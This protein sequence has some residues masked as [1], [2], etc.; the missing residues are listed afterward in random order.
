MIGK[1]RR[2][3]ISNERVARDFASRMIGLSS[4]FEMTPLPDG[5]FEAVVKDEPDVVE[6][7]SRAEED[8]LPK[9][10]GEW[11]DEELLSLALEYI[12]NQQS[13]EAWE[14]FLKEAK[15]TKARG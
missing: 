7:A 8:T 4:W 3:M 15:E 12:D 2:V 10:S 9:A 1:L 5:K 14:D 13:P 6:S 11:T